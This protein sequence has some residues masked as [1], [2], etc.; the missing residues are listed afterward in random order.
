MPVVCVHIRGEE[1]NN[2]RTET[3]RELNLPRY[4]NDEG[5]VEKLLKFQ[6]DNR[7]Y[8]V[9]GMPGSSG[10]GEYFGFFTAEDA[11][12]IWI[13]ALKQGIKLEVNE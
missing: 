3:E 12:K 9:A 5:L 10:G 13:W 4:L 2:P 8:H 6:M 7:I 11:E 1:Y